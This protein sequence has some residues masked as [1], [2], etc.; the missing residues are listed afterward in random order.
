[1]HRLPVV[2][3]YQPKTLILVIPT[4]YDMKRIIFA[5][6]LF[7]RFLP[8]GAQV[9]EQVYAHTDKEFYLAGEIIWFKLYVMDAASHR[10]VDLSKIAYVEVISGDQHPALQAKISLEEGLG[11]GSFQLPFSIHSG[12]YIFRA[13]TRWMMNARPESYFEKTITILNTLRIEEVPSPVVHPGNEAPAYDIQ[14]FPEGGSLVQGLSNRV[15]FRVADRSGS[16][17]ACKGSLVSAVGDTIARFQSLRFGMGRF[18]FIPAAGAA[19]KA[20]FELDDHTLVTHSLPSPDEKGYTMLLTAG[21]GGKLTI[22]IHSNVPGDDSIVRLYI[23]NHGSLS[24]IDQK[25]IDGGETQFIVDENKLPEGVTVFTVLTG[26]QRPVGERLWFRRPV[27]PHFVIH[28]DQEQYKARE[29]VTL[30]LSQADNSSVPLWLNA[31]MA[32]VLQD[33]LQSTGQEDILN[34]LFLSA[35]LK[36]AIDSPAYYFSSGNAEVMETTDLLMMTQGWRKLWK[37]VPGPRHKPEYAGLLV[38]GRVTDRHTDRPASGVFVWLSVPGQKFRLA[39]A[40]SDRDGELQWDLG[41]VY[42]AHELV[43]QT[44][45]SLLDRRYRIDLF[46]PFASALTQKTP[47]PFIWPTTIKDQLLVHSIGAQAQNAYQPDR[48]R[49]FS[50]PLVTDTLAF[51]GRPGKTYRLDDYTRFTTMEEVMREYVREVRV[52]NSKGNFGFYVQADQANEFFF[53]SRPLILV[54]GVPVSDVNDI[55]RFDPLKFNK[56][57]IVAKRYLFADSLYTGIISYSTYKGDLAG[58][59]LD[60]DAYILDY[61]GL[62]LHREFYSPVYDTK[63]QRTSRIPDLRT[64]LYWS[65]DITTSPSGKGEVSFYTSDMPGIYTAI[66]QGIT[67]TGQA[68]SARATFI[69]DRAL[70]VK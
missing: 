36:G 49:H 35:D 70:P 47:P 19:C 50:Q 14:F 69:V 11:N 46:N 43:V 38:T 40:V 2:R 20:V 10:P 30:Q 52:R 22:S 67:L 48:Q 4:L 21:D 58:F 32:V 61:E 26:K 33:S 53:D 29:K 28:A 3:R 68:V 12:N 63:D 6:I 59:P 27:S 18:S 45:D 5:V 55:I 64:V 31:S 56:I 57:E 41:M 37:E 39:S 1:M 9:E 25:S 34:Y 66:V 54:D 44:G 17:R 8:A 24:E 42:G 60:K 16:G 51:Y 13:Y 62:Q 15:A 23:H 65:P 7:V